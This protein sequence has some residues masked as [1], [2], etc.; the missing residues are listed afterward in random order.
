M[1][2]VKRFF[3]V[4]ISLATGIGLAV[5]WAL[6]SSLPMTEGQLAVRGLTAKV[7]VIRNS[8]GIPKITAENEL[9]GYRALG[10]IH[11]QDR[12][13]QMEMTRRVGAGRLS[14]ITGL[15]TARLDRF[16]RTMGFH[17]LAEFQA[18]KMPAE[19]RAAFDAYA[20]GVN[21]FI[22]SR[23]GFLPAEFLLFQHEPEPWTVADSLV[24]SKLMAF[25]LSNDW[26]SELMKMALARGVSNE[27]LYQL[28]PGRE[29]GS[30]VTA[31][32]EAVM[33]FAQALL[34]GMPEE[35]QPQSAS[36]AWVLGGSRTDTGL[37]VLAND[38]HLKFSLPSLWYLAQIEL[39]DRKITGVTVPGVPLH[40]L[41]QNGD[42]AWGMTTTHA[43]TQDIVLEKLDPYDPAL[44]QG[45]EEKGVLVSRTEIIV[46]RGDKPIVHTV[47]DMPGAVVVS[48]VMPELRARLP[49]DQVALLHWPGFELDDSTA[50]ALYDMNR[51]K[52][53]SQFQRAV[54]KFHAPV[55]NIHYADK[56]GNIALMVAGRIPVRGRRDGTYVSLGE[57]P[58]SRWTGLIPEPELPK[59]INPTSDLVANA[60]N[61]M[62][63]DSYPYSITPIWRASYRVERILEELS[64]IRETGDLAVSRKLQTDTQSLPARL[65]TPYLVKALQ[66]TGEAE[67]ASLMANWDHQMRLERLE[68]A[69]YTVWERRMLEMVVSDELAGNFGRYWRERPRFLHKV[70]TRQPHWCDNQNSSSVEDCSWAAKRAV[71]LALSD[72]GLWLG[73]DRS[74]WRWGDLHLGTFEHQIA[75]NVPVLDKI[76]GRSLATS[77]SDHTVSR[78]QTGAGGE[79]SSYRHSH[80]AGYRAIY[81]LADPENSVFALAG[82]QSGHPLSS[83]YADQL[84]GWRDGDYFRIVIPDQSGTNRFLT[85]LPA[86]SD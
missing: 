29:E 13:W 84:E 3:L 10:F 48:D 30:H 1:K 27:Q 19:M 66:D 4:I 32:S 80:G 43:D 25:Q 64:S 63:P 16:M 34:E 71:G 86:G 74:K 9:D 2:W 69:L 47:R 49:R 59:I 78:G 56:R 67:L 58:D 41:G 38:P 5:A 31:Q 23:T 7:Q 57:N 77:G 17:K 33:S 68:P 85:L 72:L 39:P 35:L 8:R 55:Q 42:I 62:V 6:W 18:E 24:W 44:L 53:L 46:V 37:P 54:Q 70:L 81:D 50:Y 79:R 36:N 28:F 45:G 60:N 21:E 14:E 22:D 73:K 83:N 65:M 40:I 75:K 11:A 76:F 51:A 61:R 20:A 15:D 26:R 52:D 82:G 12:L